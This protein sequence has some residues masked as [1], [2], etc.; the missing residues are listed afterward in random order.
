MKLAR[1][2]LTLFA[3][4]AC[5]LLADLL[6]LLYE[7]LAMP[8]RHDM[9]GFGIGIQFAGLALI[10]LFPFAFWLGNLWW[11]D[12]RRYL[13]NVLVLITLTAFIAPN[14]STHPY[15]TFLFLACCWSTLPL[16]W[17]IDRKTIGR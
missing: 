11:N 8:I 14:W 5:L 9:L 10:V 15:R 6:V 13:I 17:L 3:A 7:R 1:I 16:Q 12:R 2:I 4:P